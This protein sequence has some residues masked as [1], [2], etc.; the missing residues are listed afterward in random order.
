[1]KYRP[2]FPAPERAIRRE[3]SGMICEHA[4]LR[5]LA[6]T[7]PVELAYAL[8]LIGCGDYHSVTRPGS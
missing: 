8:A 5:A 2:L 7:W 6:A 4:D 1:M 3:F